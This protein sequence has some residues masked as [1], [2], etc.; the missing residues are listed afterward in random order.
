MIGHW[1]VLDSYLGWATRMAF[2]QMQSMFAAMEDLGGQLGRHSKQMQRCWRFNECFDIANIMLQ[3]MMISLYLGWAVTPSIA[4]IGVLVFLLLLVTHEPLQVLMKHL[5]D[6]TVT[7]VVTNKG[8]NQ[9]VRMSNVRLSIGVDDDNF[10]YSMRALL[11]PV[12]WL[13]S[14]TKHV[15]AA[16]SSLCVGHQGSDDDNVVFTVHSLPT[17]V[18]WLGSHTESVIAATVGIW[19]CDHIYKSE[20]HFLRQRTIV[21]LHEGKQ[22]RD[23]GGANLR[24]HSSGL[25]PAS[26]TNGDNLNT[27]TWLEV[28]VLSDV[29]LSVPPKRCCACQL[30]Q[31]HAVFNRYDELLQSAHVSSL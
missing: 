21:E 8:C 27:S 2:K 20:P 10:W 13:G 1:V 30:I 16:T 23:G 25:T 5:L 11:R 15:T 12:S 7:E 9:H 29:G 31:P 4:K 24:L 18:S 17:T 14:H 19:Y 28:Y 22:H 6:K 26:T 3:A